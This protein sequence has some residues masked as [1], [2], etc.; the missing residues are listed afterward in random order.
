MSS[1]KSTRF[2]NS[3]QTAD[4]LPQRPEV[5]NVRCAGC[6][7]EAPTTRRFCGKCGDQLWDPCLKCHEKNPVDVQYCGH[8]GSD[9]ATEVANLRKLMKEALETANELATAGRLQN[10]ISTLEPLIDVDHSQLDAFAKEIAGNI[11]QFEDTRANAIANSATVA[12]ECQQ[13]LVDRRYH[14]AHEHLERIPPALRNRQLIELAATAQAHVDE[15]NLLRAEVK[16]ALQKK[17]H[18]GALAKVARLVELTPDDQQLKKLLNQLEDRQKKSHLMQATKICAA[19]KAAIGKHEYRQAAAAVGQLHASL[20]DEAILQFV[21]GVKERAWLS[22][23]LRTAPYVTPTLL[24]IASRFCKLQPDDQRYAQVARQLQARWAKET[25]ANPAQPVRWAKVPAESRLGVPVDLLPVTKSLLG[26]QQN[27]CSPHSML[28]AFG[29]AIQAVGRGAITLDLAHQEKKSAWR[30]R[31]KRKG[32]KRPGSQGW[33]IEIGSKYLKAMQVMLPA[34]SDRVEVLKS[35]TISHAAALESQPSAAGESITA[36]VGKSIDQFLEENE[37]SGQSVVVNLPGAKTL[38]RFFDLPAAKPDRF[39]AA[40]EYELR[41]RIPLRE[42]ETVYD[43]HSFDLPRDSKQEIAQRRVMLVAANRIHAESLLRPFREAGVGNLSL[44]SDCLALH[45]AVYQELPD[46]RE[47]SEDHSVCVVEIGASG[48]N[49]LVLSPS[50]VW[51]RGIYAGMS[52]FDKALVLNRQKTRSDAEALRHRPEQAARMHEIHETLLP[53]I[54]SLTEAVQRTLNQVQHETENPV[55]RVYLCGGGSQ[56][57]GL[58]SHLQ[59]PS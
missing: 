36:E 54:Q 1:T 14:A 8:C 17:D 46:L 13:L 55:K 11:Q 53:E 45:N 50:G 19:A 51:F 57:F 49:F 26:E 42:E 47:A 24:A 43:Y 9:L 28:V 39:K 33:G 38:A 40:V 37:L 48:S 22:E 41:A 34:D 30:D 6:G 35:I 59:S 10:A 27:A 16:N 15:S 20:D 25:Q 4:G 7:E 5:S 21:A 32:S 56:Q 23:Q 18:G 12:A 31:L 2:Q 44:Q 3:E 29:L 58:L 52:Q